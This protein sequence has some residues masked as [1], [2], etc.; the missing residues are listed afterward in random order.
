MTLQ[1][2]VSIGICKICFLFLWQIFV[3]LQLSIITGENTRL[4]DS[5]CE[6]ADD[7]DMED[8]QHSPSIFPSCNPPNFETILNDLEHP[9]RNDDDHDNNYQPPNLSYQSHPDQYLP[10]YNIGNSSVNSD[11]PNNQLDDNKYSLP[12]R[13]HRNADL[14]DLSTNRFSMEGYASGNGS[15]SDMSQNLCEIEDS[16]VNYSDDDSDNVS[17]HSIRDTRL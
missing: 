9:V 10:H 12:R 8:G 17:C 6:Y 16:E 3:K 7:S 11:P 4:L 1:N 13:R 14:D 15:C 5:V 2:L